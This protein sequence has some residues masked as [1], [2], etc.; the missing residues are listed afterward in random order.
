MMAFVE[1][2]HVKSASDVCLLHVS[3]L[4]LSI[5]LEHI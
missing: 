4:P 3:R 5:Y 2:V 1:S